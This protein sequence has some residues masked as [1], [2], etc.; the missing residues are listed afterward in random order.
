MTKPKEEGTPEA[1]IVTLEKGTEVG[2]LGIKADPTP[3]ENYTVAGNDLPTPETDPDLAAKA[4]AHPQ[5]VASMK[6]EQP[7]PNKKAEG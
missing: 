4:G 5:A 6:N 3:N 2:F 1:P 7:P